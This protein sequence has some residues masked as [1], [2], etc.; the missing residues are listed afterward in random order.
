MIE[1][2][3]CGW[4]GTADYTRDGKCPK[5]GEV[6]FIDLDDTPEEEEENDNS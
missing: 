4:Y 2:S 5:C 3:G 6:E 1:C